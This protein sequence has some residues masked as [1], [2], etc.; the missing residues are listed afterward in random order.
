MAFKTKL[1]FIKRNRGPRRSA[2]A[3]PIDYNRNKRAAERSERS[4]WPRV[5]QR[6]SV[7][8]DICGL[9]GS[10]VATIPASNSTNGL[11]Y[12]RTADISRSVT[13][14]CSTIVP[15][16]FQSRTRRFSIDRLID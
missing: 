4:E 9:V 5:Q 8:T 6:S 13:P 10:S 1:T 14:R 15:R 3:R 2:V 7:Y 11:N 12:C 16:L